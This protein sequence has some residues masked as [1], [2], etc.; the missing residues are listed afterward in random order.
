MERDR[1]A[2]DPLSEWD[3]IKYGIF[4]GESG[5]DYNALFGFSNRDGGQFAGKPL[6]S[7]TVDEALAFA[8]PSGGYGQWVK[9]QIGRVATPM[10]AYQIVGTTL[11]AAKA[12]LGLTGTEKMT[13]ELQDRLGRWIY[14]QQGTGAWAGYKGPRDSYT[15]V[16]GGA[17]ASYADN[18]LATPAPQTGQNQLAAPEP[19]QWSYNAFTLDPAAFMRQPNRLA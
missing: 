3:R 12:G 8:N 1:Q 18:G 13:P 9:D 6:T 16:N 17:Q 5:G 10:G 19:P 4:A 14:E 11:K 2:Q 15:P 7:M